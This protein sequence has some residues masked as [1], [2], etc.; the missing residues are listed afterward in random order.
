MS[1]M[2]AIVSRL[3]LLP[4]RRT[5]SACAVSTIVHSP[6]RVLPTGTAM[7][8]IVDPPETRD[9]RGP[10]RYSTN[11]WWQEAAVPQYHHHAQS[12]RQTMSPFILTTPSSPTTAKTTQQFRYLS[13]SSTNRNRRR[14]SDEKPSVVFDPLSMPSSTVLKQRDQE[15]TK[16]EISLK[17][18]L[19]HYQQA[20]AQQHDEGDASLVLLQDALDNLNK[21]YMNLGYWEDALGVEQT[22]CQLFYSLPSFDDDDNNNSDDDDNDD[23]DDKDPNSD[24]YADSI[25][26]QGKLYLR[27]E[28]FRNAHD[29]YQQALDY[30]TQS[31]NTTQQG[32]VLMSL[33]GWH[34]FRGELETALELLEQSEPLLEH[35]PTL[36]VKNLDNAGLVLRCM[37]EYGLALEKYEQALQLIRV[38]QNHDDDDDDNDYV[39]ES[40][41]ET[42]IALGMHMA[43]MRVALDQPDEALELYEEIFDTLDRKPT[44]TNSGTRGV[45]MHN[46]ANLHAQQGDY[47]LALEEFNQALQL[48]ANAVGGGE[49][50]NNNNNNNNNPEVAKTWNAMG[51]LYGGVLQQTPQ[52]LECFQQALNIFRSNADH[53]ESDPDVLAVL[54][55]MTVLQQKTK[56]KKRP[57]KGNE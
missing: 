11:T 35:N 50:E 10:R 5:A 33:A 3:L 20:V 18:A 46:I 25:H 53:E 16:K 8:M 26:A 57:S 52:A 37:N 30:F 24:A 32:H 14:K 23:N 15:L 17:R 29:L 39:D 13:S 47:E 36:L 34:Y 38:G 6:L 27:L 12:I 51:A 42:R 55:N 44:L 54:R 31:G 28:D 40:L 7:M 43:D 48:K 2:A 56:T 4:L 45:L 1:Q 41:W 49:G 9:K 22:L 21:A 19:E